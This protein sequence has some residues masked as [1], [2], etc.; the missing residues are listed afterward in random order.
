[1]YFGDYERCHKEL[2]KPDESG[3]RNKALTNIYK[4]TFEKVIAL[5]HNVSEEATQKK[6]KSL[7]QS[8][9]TTFLWLGRRKK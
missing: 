5:S 1:M 2:Q 4:A 6:Y 9:L 3:I 7:L 8:K